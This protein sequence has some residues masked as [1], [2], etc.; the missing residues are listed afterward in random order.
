MNIQLN[1]RT[2]R[3]ATE[4]P[5][6]SK[7]AARKFSHGLPPSLLLSRARRL[8]GVS[9]Q[10]MAAEMGIPQSLL[11]KFEFGDLRMPTSMLLKIFMFGLDFW[12]DGIYWHVSE[13]E[14]EQAQ[15]K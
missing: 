3:T 12:S 15:R 13:E 1:K 4:K 8:L 9:R 7:L 2:E 14:A 6:V 10:M 11:R 5:P